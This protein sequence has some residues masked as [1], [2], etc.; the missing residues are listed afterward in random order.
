MTVT[1]KAVGGII[2]VAAALYQ[3][4]PLK[5]ACLRQCQTPIRFITRYQRPGLGGAL[6][7][8]VRHGA[9]C[10]GCCALLMVLLFFGGIMNLFWI[11]GLSITVMLEKLL[12]HGRWV[13][14]AAAI[15][16]LAGGAALLLS[17][18]WA[19]PHIP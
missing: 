7:L 1:N 17:A 12:P 8:G 4:S 2:L 6:R 11:A 13:G 16:L 14:Y 10:V 18:L 9:Y 15:G 5:Q 19:P 3:F